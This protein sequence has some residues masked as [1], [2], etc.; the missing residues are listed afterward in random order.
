MSE[1]PQA[2]QIALAGR[3]VEIRPMYSQIR[4][5]CRDYILPDRREADISISLGELDIE[6]EAEIARREEEGTGIQT[7]YSPAYLETVGAYR[8]IVEALASLD[9]LL[10]HGSVVSTDGQGIMFTAPSGTGKSTRT[11]LWLDT[12][13]SSIVV[14]GDKPLL[15]VTES[16]VLAYGTPWCGKEGWNTNTSVPLKAIFL[17]E[18]SE[19]G[20]FIRELSF[21]EAFPKLIRHTYL[22]G[23]AIVRRKTL[24]LL[25]SMAGKVKVFQFKSEPTAEAIKMAWNAVRNEQSQEKGQNGVQC[26]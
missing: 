15:R 16:Q 2:F 6:H 11:K 10:V 7:F 26:R 12:I 5:L 14:N 20:N 19:S 22:T 18:R 8:H 13:D 23:N 3:I 1:A 9:T 17:L 24:N 21:S 25:R 4:A